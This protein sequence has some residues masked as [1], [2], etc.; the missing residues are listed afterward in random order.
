MTKPTKRVRKVIYEDKDDGEYTPTEKDMRHESSR[1]RTRKTVRFASSKVEDEPDLSEVD[2]LI[3][4]ATWTTV[5]D[6]MDTVGQGCPQIVPNGGEPELPNTD[7]NAEVEITTVDNS[8]TPGQ[9]DEGDEFRD[10]MAQ[11]M[12]DSEI[13][14]DEGEEWENADRAFDPDAGSKADSDLDM[15]LEKK[16]RDLIAAELP[17]DVISRVQHTSQADFDLMVAMFPLIKQEDLFNTT[18]VEVPNW[19]LALTINPYQLMAAA[20]TWMWKRQYEHG[21]ICG[22]PTGAGKT[23]I[24]GL[25][26]AIE[27]FFYQMVFDVEEA[28]SLGKTDKHLARDGQTETSA[29]PSWKSN[30]LPCY[31]VE[32]NR[33]KL[34]PFRPLR[35]FTLALTLPGVVMQYCTDIMKLFHGGE[36]MKRPHPPQFRHLAR[37]DMVHPLVTRASQKDFTFLSKDQDWSDFARRKA[38]QTEHRTASATYAIDWQ[39][40]YVSGGPPNPDATIYESA[41]HASSYFIMASTTM[42]GK[43]PSYF[44]V[45]KQAYWKHPRCTEKTMSSEV[46]NGMQIAHIIWDECHLN[47]HDSLVT[48]LIS[49]AR[50]KYRTDMYALEQGEHTI[51]N[52]LEDLR[53]A[54]HALLTAEIDGCKARVVELIQQVKFST[55]EYT[56]LEERTTKLS[57]LLVLLDEPEFRPYHMRDFANRF[58]ALGGSFTGQERQTIKDTYSDWA[59]DI[60]EP[61]LIG[62]TG[63][64][65]A[66]DM[67]TV[68]NFS[69]SSLWCQQWGE[70]TPR[71]L[72]DLPGFEKAK[73]D[74]SAHIAV[75]NATRL[76]A[77]KKTLTKLSLS[78]RADANFLLDSDEFKDLAK[79][80]SQIWVRSIIRREYE[81]LWF[82]GK[83]IIPKDCVMALEFVECKP[84]TGSVEADTIKNEAEQALAAMKTQFDTQVADWEA[85]GQRGKRPEFR[86]AQCRNG[87]INAVYAASVGPAINKF[88]KFLCKAANSKSAVA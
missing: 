78:A 2:A 45:K 85:N 35:G 43:I 79:M 21:G 7:V 15:Q 77:I 4:D 19:G 26:F 31:C 56:E 29:C 84:E 32:A 8:V 36:I 87:F 81:A 3:G 12:I 50:R 25:L 65:G 49:T 17:K 11:Y 48:K 40:K 6:K 24:Q 42:A 16:V 46:K 23:V 57:E 28:R 18:P 70:L 37:V 73:R 58:E 71:A 34:Y 9:T 61:T 51:L 54:R 13:Q 88:G 33:A 66:G 38:E 68:I 55:P 75:I 63:T 80:T 30:A 60:R 59:V 74:K 10:A 41:P 22:D 62:F 52:E 72:R 64:P 86:P 76:A 14:Q 27:Y 67:M 82:N 69:A 39:D 1:P 44:D 20:I 83:R 5:P 53:V 47:I